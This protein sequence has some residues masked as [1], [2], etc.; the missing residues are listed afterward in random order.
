[1][2]TMRSERRWRTRTSLF[3]PILLIGA[4][5][6]LLMDMQ[7]LLVNRPLALLATYWPVLFIVAGIE[8]LL[9]REGWLSKAVTA[10]MGVVIV[11]GAIWMLT[12]PTIVL[13]MPIYFNLN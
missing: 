8:L 13:Q 12:S 10:L 4:G 5:I 1:M 7:G 6:I 2:S 9:P 11:A 3:W